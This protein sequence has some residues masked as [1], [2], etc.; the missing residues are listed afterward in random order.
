MKIALIGTAPSAAHAP[1]DDKSWEIWGTGARG[2]CVTRA[3]RW[4]ELHRISLRP[5]A[6]EF[7]RAVKEWAR[8]LPLYMLYPEKNLGDVLEY[9]REN[10]EDEFGSHW[11]SSS[12]AW[13]FAF[14]M[15]DGAKEIALYGV[16]MEYGTEYAEQK[17][18]LKSLICVAQNRGVTV[19]VM[20][21]SGLAYK[22][23]AYPECLEDPIRM[24]MKLRATMMT[25][26]Q[27]EC[28][29]SLRVN[30]QKIASA[31][32]KIE[33]ARASQDK[34]YSADERILEL[35]GMLDSLYATSAELHRESMRLE[36]QKEEQDWLGDY[37]A[38]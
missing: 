14:A 8:G 2:Q 13:M 26:F 27:K 33:E 32:S 5:Q 11:M 38:P 9:P 15:Y 34:K 16:D 10:V 35:A 18:G 37:I 36:G 4:F 12:F 1:Y 17:N 24:K 31:N 7:R 23:P 19:R 22:T 3:T 30:D 28:T 20:A 29:E 21:D 6:D 25:G